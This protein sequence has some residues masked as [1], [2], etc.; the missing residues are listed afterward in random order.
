MA[1]TRSTTP[2][3]WFAALK[4]STHRIE[5]QL[6]AYRAEVSG[7]RDGMVALMEAVAQLS[8]NNNMRTNNDNTEYEK[9]DEALAKLCQTG[10]ICEYQTQ[11]EHLAAW[12]HNLSE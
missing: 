2:D 5:W 10:T 3:E 4:V 11:F 9:F 6:E 8:R 1:S 12:V 7:I